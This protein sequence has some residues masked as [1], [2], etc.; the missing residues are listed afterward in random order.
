VTNTGQAPAVNVVVTDA[1]DPGLIHQSG[2]GPVQMTL[3]DLAPGQSRTVEIVLT[4][5]AAGRF[6]NRATATADGGLSASAEHCVEVTQPALEITKQ[7]PKF[8]F[9]GAPVEFT[10]TVRNT[11]A[12]AAE[13]VVVTDRL[14]AQLQ[15]QQASS[16]G[17][18]QG[19]TVTWNLGTLQPAQQVTLQLL[20]LASEV[21]EN[22]CNTAIVTANGGIH[23]PSEPACLNIRGVPALLTELIDRFDPVPLGGETT[24]TIQ[25]TNQGSLPAHDVT[26]LC[27]LPDGLE[28]V[29]AEGAPAFKYDEQ[30]RTVTFEPFRD[31]TGAG[32]APRKRLRYQV[33]AKAA[34]PGDHRFEA[35]IS[36]RELKTDIVIQESTTVYDPE[37]GATNGSAARRDAHPTDHLLPTGAGQP[38]PNA[39]SSSNVGAADE[40]EREPA[41]APKAGSS[42]ETGTSLSV[43]PLFPVVPTDEPQDASTAA[44]GNQP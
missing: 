15:P 30:T 21:G 37:T 43:A 1:F 25:I 13:N 41:D 12:I 35:R 10:I 26:V 42:Q 23:L 29:G 11:G 27:K 31:A 40:H 39:H 22:V 34:K 8:A 7:G 19:G 38:A 28:F 18:V 4:P 44:P 16:G 24:Y 20:A 36:A 6:C 2:A 17:I 32:M 3:G 33:Q 5:R 9:V 14:P